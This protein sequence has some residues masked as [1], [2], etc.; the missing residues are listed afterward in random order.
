MFHHRYPAS[1]YFLTIQVCYIMSQL[2]FFFF[3]YLLLLSSTLIVHSGPS[4]CYFPC[5]LVP[6]SSSFWL[7]SLILLEHILQ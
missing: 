5:F 6:I 2:L 4:I 3:D 1:I 7:Y